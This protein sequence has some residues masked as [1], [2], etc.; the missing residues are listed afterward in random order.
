MCEGIVLLLGLS[1]RRTN[2]VFDGSL[3]RDLCHKRF[4]VDTNS[5][6]AIST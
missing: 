4:S 5:D 1:G 6:I 2:V 3:P